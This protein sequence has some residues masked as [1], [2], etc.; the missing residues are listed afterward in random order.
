MRRPRRVRRPSLHSVSTT[1][2]RNTSRSSTPATRSPPSRGA[3]R[4]SWRTSA[5]SRRRCASSMPAWAMPPCSRAS[6]AARIARFPP[7]R[8]SP[9]PRKSASKTCASAS[10]RCRTAST[11]IPATVLVITNL[12]YAEAP[13]LMPRDT[14]FAAALNWQEVK[15]TGNSA[16]EYAEQIE[17]LGADAHLRLADAAE[18]EE[19]QPG[20]PAPLG[21]RAL[22]R[23]SQ[24]P[25]GL[26]D[27]EARP[28]LRELR[29]DPRLAAVA[30]A[31]VRGVQGAESARAAHAQPRPGRTAARDPVGGQG[32]GARDHPEALAGRKP[33]PGGSPR[34]A[35]RAE[36]RA[37]PRRAR[38]HAHRAAGRQGHLPLRDAHAAVGDLRTASAPR[39]CLPPGTPPS[40]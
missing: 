4:R 28:H 24:V 40:T 7:C 2:A 30:R 32:S 29:P 39:R 21:A 26:G 5:R 22:P 31:H 3:W 15:L 27:P 11:S 18:H 34:A 23:G 19:R 13:R 17:E 16:H 35:R 1:T 33:L 37:R 25:A 38:L 14:H 8:C 20:V 6:C 36:E 12:N 9:S 10:R